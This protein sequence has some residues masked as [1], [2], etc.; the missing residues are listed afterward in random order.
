MSLNIFEIIKNMD[1]TINENNNFKNIIENQNEAVI[2][3]SKG[4]QIE[5][6]NA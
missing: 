5:Y 6:V 4:C 3:V 2:I 1:E